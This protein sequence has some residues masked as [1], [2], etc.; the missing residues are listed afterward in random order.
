MGTWPFET[1]VRVIAALTE[2]NSVRGT[3]RLEKVDKNAV[4][5]LA[6]R[7][8]DGCG[9]LHDRIVRKLPTLVIQGDE[10]WS[11]IFCKEARV[12]PTRHPAEYGDAYTFIGLDALAK[13]VIS[14]LVGK[15]DAEHADLFARDMRARLVYCPH[16]ATD[17]FNAYPS[18]IASHFGGAVDY[19][20]AIKH[21]RSGA[22]RGPDHRYEPP[23]DP[24]VTKHTVLGAPREELVSTPYVERYN[25]TQRHIVGR[26]RRLCLAFSKTL[27]GHQAAVALGIF[28]YNFCRE[29]SALGL[30]TT[31]AMA[32][33]LT[34][35]PWTIAELV[36]AALAEEPSEKPEPAP[37]VMPAERAGQP[38]GA[39]RPLPN[40]G[41]LRVVGGAAPAV[42]GAPV[43]PPPPAGPAPVPA[44]P[45]VAIV[46]ATAEPRADPS[47][48]LDLLSWRPRPAPE[49]PS[50]PPVAPV[51]ATSKHLPP[52]Q[53]GLF[54][55]DLDPGP[56]K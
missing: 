40:G 1:R 10:T 22:I 19:G 7:V 39:A 54:G 46:P 8:G 12:D 15:R 3:A 21:Y 34:D 20:V 48:Q 23:R 47:G 32:A 41:W 9:W 37:L 11:Y 14:Y 51:P 36:E 33:G 29:H 49:A 26:T 43:V 6:L 27:R 5:N 17:G 31:P 18:V 44:A 24:F 56:G 42:K 2:G 50:P 30:H 16:L 35:H 38:V 4:L 25:L 53:L 55:L 52:G 45:A 28:A 13:L